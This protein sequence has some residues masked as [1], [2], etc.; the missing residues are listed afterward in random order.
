MQLEGID[1]FVAV[2]DARSFSR[3]AE[4][5]GMPTS[6]VSAKIARLEERLGVTL[7]Q[8]TTRQLQITAAGE[9]YYRRCLGALDQLSQGEKE[10]AMAS[11]EPVGVLRI[12]AP[13]NLC[14]SLLPPLI[15]AFLAAHPKASVD[16]IASDRKRDLIADRIDLAV[17]PG[18]MVDSSLVAR[19]LRLSALQL[20][21]SEDYLAKRG[22]PV[23]SRDLATHDL[24]LCGPFNGQVSLE[25]PAGD[26]IELN[27]PARIR[28][29]GFDTAR[30][31]VAR[32]NGIG[33]LPD[34]VGEENSHAAPL[35][36][37]LP[38]Y[39]IGHCAIH[40]V[41]PAQRFVPPA[42]RAFIDIATTPQIPMR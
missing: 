42:V 14:H 38:D 25:S 2:V 5:L 39:G 35:V 15:E 11:A 23:T 6:T 17:W 40:I 27:F 12:T 29:D 10:L 3:A 34:I 26:R 37:V 32:G 13:T 7:I 24:V 8:R 18:D 19:K 33:L 31:F 36:R 16:V 22:V 1:V 9:S 21:A 30:T 4:K 28:T 41:Y 20:W